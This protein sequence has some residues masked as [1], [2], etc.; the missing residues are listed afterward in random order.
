MSCQLGGERGLA[1]ARQPIHQY[2]AINHS[3]HALTPT[4][5][6]MR[7]MSSIWWD[8]SVKHVP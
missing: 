4:A 2:Q 6:L 1:G 8:A 7:I 5:V 3:R